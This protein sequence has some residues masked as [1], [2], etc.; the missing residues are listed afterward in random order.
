MDHSVLLKNMWAIINKKTNQ[1]V[2]ILEPTAMQDEIEKK[3]K[4]YNLVAMTIEN[5]PAYLYGYYVNNKFTKPI[6]NLKGE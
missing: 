2:D 3:S 5:S 1:V 4:K 6:E